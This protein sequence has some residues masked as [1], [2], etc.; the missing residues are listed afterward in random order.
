MPDESFTLTIDLQ[1][2]YRFLV[3]FDQDNVPPL[4]MDE[5]APLG[6]GTGPNASRVLAAA[7]GNC[8]SA[9]MLYCLRREHL[10]VTAMRTTVSGTLER[11]DAGRLRIGGIRVRLEPT[12]PKEQQ[13][14]MRRCLELFEDYCIVTQSVREGIEVDVEVEPA[15]EPAVS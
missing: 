13:P 15:G 9:S 2:D 8:L 6:D 12:V 14:R 4:L 1:D 10:D 11:N 7:I 3:E 5:P